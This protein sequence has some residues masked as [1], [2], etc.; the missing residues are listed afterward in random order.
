[1]GVI[2]ALTV[3]SGTLSVGPREVRLAWS[4]DDS[5]EYTGSEISYAGA[6][7]DPSSLFA[8]DDVTV[9]L[10]SGTDGIGAGSYLA[11]VMSLTGEDAASYCP[12][13]DATHAWEVRRAE[14]WCE[15]TPTPWTYGQDPRPADATARFGSPIVEYALA[16]TSDFSADPPAH[17]GQYVVRAT[18]AA[19][20]D[21]EGATSEAPVEVSRAQ[22]VVRALDRVADEL[23]EVPATDSPAEGVDYLLDGEDR[24]PSPPPTRR[25][26][27]TCS[28]RPTPAPTTR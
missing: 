19:S 3:L 15:V 13:T 23:G 1:M 17:A 6:T 28:A 27:G 8:G 9:G 4:G 7:V 25:A 14:N 22:L 12:P 21:W 18:V 16:G 24:R 10:Q 11:I 26:P 5:F 20:S 2:G